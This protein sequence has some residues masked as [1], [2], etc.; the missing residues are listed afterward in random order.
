MTKTAV[1]WCLLEVELSEPLRRRYYTMADKLRT[2]SAQLL[3]HM[4]YGLKPWPI[5]RRPVEEISVEG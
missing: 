2:R 3:F 4:G 5:P 1:V